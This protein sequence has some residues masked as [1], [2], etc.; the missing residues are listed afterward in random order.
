MARM[1]L[2]ALLPPLLLLGGCDPS[3]ASLDVLRLTAF[4]QDGDEGVFLNETLVFHFSGELDRSSVTRETVR[5]SAP[6]GTPAAGELRVVGTQLHFLPDLPRAPGLF[7]GGLLPDAEYRVELLGFPLPDGLRGKGGEPLSACHRFR[8]ATVAR[9]LSDQPVFDAWSEEIPILRVVDTALGPLDPILLE[10]AQP[11]D[12]RTIRGD[13][14][15]LLSTAGGG[16]G[17]ERLRLRAKLIENER[18][19]A[20]IELRALGERGSSALRVLP[21]GDYYLK[22]AEEHAAFAEGASRPRNFAGVPVEPRWSVALSVHGVRVVVN[23]I[24]PEEKPFAFDDDEYRSPQ[25][26]PGADG[27]ADWCDTIWSPKGSVSLRYPAAAGTGA[28]GDVV[29]GARDVGPDVHAATLRLPQESFVELPPSGLV[30][31]RS[32]GAIDIEGELRRAAPPGD[33]PPMTFAVGD[34]LSEWLERARADESPWTVLVAGGDIRVPG[35]L[36]FGGRLLLVAG[37][38][39]RISGSARG[40]EIRKIGPGGGFVQSGTM[41]FASW[42]EE[43]RVT[44]PE[45]PEEPWRRFVV[46]EPVENPLVRPLTFAVL[47][48]PYRPEYGVELWRPAEIRGDPGAGSFRLRYHGLRDVGPRGVEEFGP[49]DDIL[50]LQGCE[51]L[52]ILIELTLPADGGS[53]DPPK[54]D[55]VELRWN[56]PP[57]EIVET[58]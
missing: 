40:R 23:T 47:S 2:R 15:A 45:D 57:R 32:Q 43:A 53:W 11:L 42:V 12:P 18:D 34:T 5:I 33:D 27:T 36:D 54:V 46:D 29:L 49:V 50:L 55:Y 37:G 20:R 16:A 30:V 21:D 52:R 48:A 38:R 7:D 39:I 4:A 8:F 1:R 56:E 35:R 9:P 17:G 6:D 26:V 25:R 13:D 19:R 51:A 41:P 10:V 14:F 3:P 44:P 22:L 58:R 31:L 24:V 28:D